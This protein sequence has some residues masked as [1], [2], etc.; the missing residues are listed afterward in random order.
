MRNVFIKSRKTWVLSRDSQLHFSYHTQ[1][2]FTQTKLKYF[3]DNFSKE[4]MK[5]VSTKNMT[6]TTC[7]SQETPVK[8]KRL[9]L[10]WCLLFRTH[11]ECSLATTAIKSHFFNIVIFH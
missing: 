2:S 6:P 9:D 7:N 10:N 3:N 8:K 4:T 11:R 1:F 5:K